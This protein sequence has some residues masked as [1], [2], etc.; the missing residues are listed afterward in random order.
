MKCGDCCGIQKGADTDIFPPLP[1]AGAK[2][3]NG[4]EIT[5]YEDEKYLKWPYFGTGAPEAEGIKPAPEYA[6]WKW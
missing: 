2:T 6:R 5:Y 3:Y 4:H 1:P